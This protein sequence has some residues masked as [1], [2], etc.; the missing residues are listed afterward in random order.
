MIMKERTPDSFNIAD[1][2]DIDQ[3]IVAEQN[4]EQLKN[5]ISKQSL[6]SDLSDEQPET[7]IQIPWETQNTRYA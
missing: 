7:D 1:S 3:N 5:I 2:I 6:H 4:Y